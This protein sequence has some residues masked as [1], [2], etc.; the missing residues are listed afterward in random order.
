MIKS[1][2]STFEHQIQTDIVRMKKS[3]QGELQTNWIFTARRLTSGCFFLI[4]VIISGCGS[5]DKDQ[6]SAQRPA[7]Q[8]PKLTQGKDQTVRSAT[9]PK[10]LPRT[11][12]G[13]SNDSLTR[14]WFNEVTSA[15]GVN[16]VYSDGS[17]SGFYQL[18]ESVG[19]GVIVT[20][21]DAD[22]WP[23][24]LFPGGGTLNGTDSITVS[25]RSAGL[26]RNQSDC[27]FT[28]ATHISGIEDDSLYTHGGTAADINSDGFEDLIV[29][30]FGGVQ[31]WI[32]NGDGTFEQDRTLV[33]FP[34][35]RWA[36]SCV[37]TDFNLDGIA[38]LYLLTY[39]DWKPNADRRC[40]ND[41]QLR[42]I[43]G[44]T[45]FDGIQDV[46]YRG[47]GEGFTDATVTMGLVPGNRG[48]G[49]IAADFNGDSRPDLAVVNDV[50]ENQL[51]LNIEGDSFR[52]DSLIWGMAYSDTG[53]RE[54]SM[55]VAAGDYDQDGLLDFWYTNY[56]QQDNSL[57]RNSSNSGFL[58]T[59][60]I[61]G[62]RG[63]SRKWVGFGTGF[64]DF[65]CDGWDD[66]FVINGHV[67]YE[68]LD[69]PYFQP[70]Q[71]FRNMDGTSF[72]DVSNS[73]GPYFSS[74]H[75]GRG[76]ATLD[77]DNNGT[78]DLVVSH[79]NDPV[80]ILQNTHQCNHWISL[81]LVA[82]TSQ[83][84]AT[85]AVVSI[86]IEPGK[87]LKKWRVSGGSYLSQGDRR[88]MFALPSDRSINA[89]VTWPGGAE[90]E[91]RMLPT[92]SVHTLIQGR[93]DDV[94]P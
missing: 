81:D 1:H 43:C 57:L 74:T 53:E 9:L 26:F 82:V 77:I 16:F 93:G 31:V 75:S 85:G 48:L 7:I 24:L 84:S 27:K 76:A 86:E 19:G 23:D 17:D 41:Q 59:T 12:P 52:E 45:M 8:T 28:N 68:R 67:A 35:N 50:Q 78:A 70:P 15:S 21:Y 42:D 20:D 56:A 73:G 25:G 63:V 80:S 87:E 37:V 44:P 51:Y 29:C 13:S 94:S 83:H 10:D 4:V 54:G 89:V 65:D 14:P 58:Q 64:A 40:L 47:T 22:G 11:L 34:T 55:G 6:P 88:L 49:I 60:G 38:D 39:A 36:V 61:M 72:I 5:A 91:F 71:L 30:G 66:L 79:Q 62:L 2:S 90:E 46:L 33:E 69:S 32:N 3:T 92:N 18:L